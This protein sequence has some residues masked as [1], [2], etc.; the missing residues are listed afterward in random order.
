MRTRTMRKK[1]GRWAMECVEAAF[2]LFSIFPGT[3]SSQG[4]K[5]W[6]V[7]I[8]DSYNSSAPDLDNV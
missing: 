6:R 3:Q 1:R 8:S 4:T 5:K 7:P 2:S